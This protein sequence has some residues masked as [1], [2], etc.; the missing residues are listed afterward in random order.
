MNNVSIGNNVEQ[1]ICKMFAKHHYWAYNCPK[2]ASGGQPVDVIAYRGG[3]DDGRHSKFWYVDGKN[4]NFKKVSFVL[5]RTEDNQIM[6]MDYVIHFAKA[7]NKYVGFVVY[8][9][10]TENYYWLPYEKV[11]EVNKSGSKSINLSEMRLFE[12]VL[13]ESDNW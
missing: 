11:L 1:T 13:N 3:E 10:R 8:F 12:E 4:V 5:D 6:S 2:N 9:E 7:N